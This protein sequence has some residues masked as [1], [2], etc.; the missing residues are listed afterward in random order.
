MKKMQVISD[1]LL[2]NCC[3]ISLLKG[4][5]FGFSIDLL[6]VHIQ[7]QFYTWNE[8]SKVFVNNTL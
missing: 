3:G 7:L 6:C 2:D 1:F 8:G 5:L 4:L